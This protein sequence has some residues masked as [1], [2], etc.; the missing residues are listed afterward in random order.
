MRVLEIQGAFGL[1]NLKL[2]ERPEPTPGPGEVVV[3]MQA[4][5]LNFRDLLTV[6]GAYGGAIRLPLIPF[7][8]GAGIIHAVGEGVSRVKVGDRVSSLFFSDTWLSGPPT[9]EKLSGSLGGPRDGCGQEFMLISQ[10]GVSKVPSHLSALAAS[11]LPCAALTAWRALV[12]DGDLKAGDAVVLQGTGGVSIFAL[13][14]AKAMGLNTI[15]TSSSD[16]KLERAKALGA[17]HT[18]NYKATP[19]WAAEVRKLTG[20]RGA[21]CVVEVGGAQTLSESLKAVR[22]G[23]HIPIIGLLSGVAEAAPIPLL[24]RSS[25]RVQGLAVGS[26]EAFEDMCRAIDLHK[27]EPVVDQ[28]FP[29]PAGA[30]ALEAMQSQSHFGKIVIQFS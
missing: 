24:I 6:T 23:G 9:L 8:D 26:R 20:G 30:A 15:I 13:Q 3:R 29:F 12:V 28:V 25:A 11:T 18:I 10:H 7:S 5:S 1:D 22:I 14:F 17:D 27:I 4:V 21:D 2:A 19:G 16:E